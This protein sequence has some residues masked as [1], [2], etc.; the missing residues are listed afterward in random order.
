MN[1]KFIIIDGPAVLHRAWHALPKLTD[2]KGRIISA[3]YGFTSLLIKLLREQKPKYIAVTFDTPEP[4][5]RHKEY[6]EYKATRVPQPKEFYD[7]IPLTKGI[8][9]A[10]NIPYFEKPGIEADDLIGALKNLAKKESIKTI[11]VTGD[12]D[13]LQLIDKKTKVYLLRKGISKAEIYDESKVTERFHLRPKQLI[14]FKALRGDPSDN[15]PGVPGIG[16]KTALKLIKKYNSL[17]NLYYCLEKNKKSCQI[18][19]RIK[20]KLLKYKNQAFLSK[21]LVTIL[22]KVDLIKNLSQCKVK[23]FDEE[24]IENEF[25]KYGFKTLIKRLE[26]GFIFN[27]QGSLF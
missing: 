23:K 1:E 26:K 12:L 9:D 27:Q 24:K 8:L 11:I 13:A 18:K 7:Q 25:K 22:S 10:F 6:K 19:D 17:E 3:V 21:R 2:P 4:T 14:D 15:I 20:E 5:F 16:K